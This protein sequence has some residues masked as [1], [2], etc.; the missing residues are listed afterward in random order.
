MGEV[1]P[2]S[3]CAAAAVVPAGFRHFCPV[4]WWCLQCAP[5]SP[6]KTEVR[7][8]VHCFPRARTSFQ[9]ATLGLGGMLDRRDPFYFFSLRIRSCVPEVPCT[10][11]LSG[12]NTSGPGPA[13]TNGCILSAHFWIESSCGSLHIYYTKIKV[14]VGPRAKFVYGVFSS[15]APSS[16]CCSHCL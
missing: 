16:S 4:I 5:C 13:K 3:Q 2:E 1:G 12:L 8:S 10:S 15:L 6:L 9:Q 7:V 11:H 14:K